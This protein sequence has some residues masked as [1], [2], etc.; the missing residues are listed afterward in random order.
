MAENDI[1]VYGMS[2]WLNLQ[3]LV[4]SV[5]EFKMKHLIQVTPTACICMLTDACEYL[6]D[7]MRSNRVLMILMSASC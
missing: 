6:I 5:T 4:R 7:V 3:L 2:A 1:L